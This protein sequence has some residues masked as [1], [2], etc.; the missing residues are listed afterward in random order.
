MEVMNANVKKDLLEM[1]L[2]VY[3][4][5]NHKNCRISPDICH[6][7]AGCQ[8]DGTCKCL[9][10]YE[11]DGVTECKRSSVTDSFD[12]N[13]TSTS[14]RPYFTTESF[15]TSTVTDRHCSARDRTAC[16]VLATCDLDTN[17][18]VCRQG[19]MGDGYIACTRIWEDCTAD[20]SMC[21]LNA[22]C[23]SETK[24]CQCNLGYIGDGISCVP[25]KM[26]CVIR[27]NLCSE[28]AECVA[29]RCV[30]GPGFTGD[31]SVCMPIEPPQFIAD[32][33]CLSDGR[34]ECKRGL[35][36]DGVECL[37]PLTAA[38][39]FGTSAPQLIH[40]EC[41]SSCGS[42]AECINGACKCSPGYIADE[43]SAC[44]DIDECKMQ[45]AQCH[46]NAQ[47][48]NQEGTYEC[49][50]LS[51]YSGN[52]K[53]CSFA[54]QENPDGLKVEC[55]DDG[56]NVVLI[57]ETS[58]FNGRIFVRGQ[59]ENP[60]CT[61]TFNG[62]ETLPLAF[63]V[64]IAHC[65]M[66]LE[67]NDTL[68]VTVIIQKHPMFVT[69]Q[70]YAYRLKC[71]YP[72]ATRNIMSHYNV[73]EITTA[74][75]I[76]TK[77]VEPACQLTVT[78]ERNVTVDSAIVGQVL[79]LALFVLPNDSF[80]VLPRNCYAI[81]L[82]TSQRYTLTDEAGCAIDAQLFPEWTRINPSLTHAVFR[83][84]KWPDSSM[85]RFECDCSACVTDCPEINCDRHREE[86][87]AKMRVARDDGAVFLPENQDALWLKNGQT[88]TK[89]S[90][91]YSAVVVV[92]DDAE[93]QLAQKQVED[94]LYK[95]SL[96]DNE[97]FS[98]LDEDRICVSAPWAVLC[99]FSVLISVSLLLTMTQIYKRRISKKKAELRNHATNYNDN[100]SA[101]I[102]F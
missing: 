61:K 74:E 25:D 85:I 100:N 101:Y 72:T 97:F 47:C 63:H 10:G 23:D 78:N 21:H 75:T 65:D 91:A 28:M 94:W 62:S 80:T 95:G 16:H 29:R 82:E 11:G 32:A 17:E 37:K 83:T 4:Q 99:L 5:I 51:G 70:A 86:Q 77:G 20:T 30:C 34:C 45:T 22:A 48:I 35:M 8:P 40:F 36:G 55:K 81:N 93:E 87:K 14:R 6:T 92:M 27:S 90:S 66:Q 9:R 50:C 49:R 19:F 79:K 39:I 43:R 12:E 54:A 67:A 71:T 58:S 98:N 15:F 73:S 13:E 56:I 57:E 64:P 41:P 7:N 96:H 88:I 26:D 76:N 44:I 59:S 38:E 18:C 52:G 89:P 1:V 33:T 60:F 84:F 3:Q 42:N 69:E 24:Q 102:K 53:E 2:N 31:G 46:I 68:A